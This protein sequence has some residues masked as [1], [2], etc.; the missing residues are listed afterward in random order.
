M[1]TIY[2][3]IVEIVVKS[4]WRMENRQEICNLLSW[5]KV[6]IIIEYTYQY[7]VVWNQYRLSSH[8][9]IQIKQK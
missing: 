4:N 2:G 6:N 7:F 1:D 9:S 8:Y 3:E 5:K